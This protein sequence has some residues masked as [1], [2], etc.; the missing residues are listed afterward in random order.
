MEAKCE[1]VYVSPV[2]WVSGHK[3]VCAVQESACSVESEAVSD[4]LSSGSLYPAT[5]Q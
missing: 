5:H 2:S 4:G 1:E 3:D